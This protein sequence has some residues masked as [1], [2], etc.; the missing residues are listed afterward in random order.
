MINGSNNI[1]SVVRQRRAMVPLTLRELAAES[2]VS[3]SLLSRIE[4]G[5]RFPSAHTLCKIA[6]PLGL[7]AGELFSCA[8]YLPPQT[9]SAVESPTTRRLDPQ[10]VAAL[11]QE[12]FDVQRTVLTILSLLKIMGK[13]TTQ[14][15]SKAAHTE[16]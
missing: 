12:T 6:K 15:H 14:Q 9:S 4:R 11:S 13:G 7:G 2:G 16:S 5:K 8:G 1:S 10:V 3:P